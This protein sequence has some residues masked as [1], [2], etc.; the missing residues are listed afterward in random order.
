MVVIGGHDEDFDLI[1]DQLHAYLQHLPQERIAVDPRTL[2]R[3]ELSN[4]VAAEINLQRTRQ[5]EGLLERLLG[6]VD[7]HGL[8]V[9][10]LA[11]VLEASNAH[12]V[13]HLVVAGR[14]AK[15]G[16]MC[17]NCGWLA[18]TGSECPVCR[19]GLF[20]VDD[21]ISAAMDTTVETGGRV[22]IVSVASRLD[23][24]GVAALTRFAVG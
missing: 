1:S 5:E 22:T 4:L 21:V 8:A 6:E 20:A 24:V 23:A 9:A 13:D 14:Y 2:A 17:D 11:A 16:V 12:A 7:G 10:G 3:A 15:E 19:S 18:R